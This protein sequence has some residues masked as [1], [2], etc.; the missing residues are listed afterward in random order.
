MTGSI[1]G[2]TEGILLTLA[3][4]AVFGI[5]VGGFNLMYGQNHNVGI[6]D[7]SGT[8]QLFIEYQDTSEQQ[9]KGGDVE[10]DA[11]QGITLKSSYGITK[12]ALNIA[13]SFISGGFIEQLA[14]AWNVGEAGLIFAKALRIIYFL[15]LVFGLLYLLFKVIP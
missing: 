6:T 11:Q 15:S 4:L 8:E 12:D 13:W 2:W 10:F 7:N 1:S 9:I 14:Q 5:V 3:F